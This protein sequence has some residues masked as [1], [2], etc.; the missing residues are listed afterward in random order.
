M[1][2]PLQRH[3]KAEVA[4][5]HPDSRAADTGVSGMLHEDITLSGTPNT[6]TTIT[7]P[8]DAI[9]YRLSNASA[10]CRFN[11]NADPVQAA[12]LSS[13]TI[14]VANMKAGNRLASGTAETR[15]LEP[16]VA[17]NGGVTTGRTLRILS[18]TASATLT[19][20]VW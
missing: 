1:P 6:V 8:D 12:G 7:L 2:S 4:F 20:E 9:G 15:I 10:V 5:I 14:A 19:V 18:A 16:V 3:T 17:T 13:T 11:V